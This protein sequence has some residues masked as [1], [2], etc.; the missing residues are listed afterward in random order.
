MPGPLVK[1]KPFPGLDK[2][3]T[4]LRG[5]VEAVYPQQPS[6][7]VVGMTLG[8]AQKALKYLLP[9]RPHPNIP[10][11]HDLMARFGPE[12]TQEAGSMLRA[13]RGTPTEGRS[14]LQKMIQDTAIGRVGPLKPPLL[15]GQRQPIPGNALYEVLERAAEKQGAGMGNT[16]GEAGLL[17]QYM[18]PILKRF[19]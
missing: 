9:Q 16:P 1:S 12:P 17:Q 14:V 13:L 3:P 11:A 19:R 10:G 6:L 8:P 18:E 5:L 15:K 4:P 2:L 7:P